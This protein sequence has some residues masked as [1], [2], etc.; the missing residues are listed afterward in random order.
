MEFYWLH[1]LLVWV[2]HIFVSH[3]E[4]KLKKKTNKKNSS[5]NTNLVTSPVHLVYCSVCPWFHYNEAV[6]LWGIVGS[7]DSS[8]FFLSSISLLIPFFLVHV[9]SGTVYP[10]SYF[11]WAKISKVVIW[12]K[13]TSGGDGYIWTIL[14]AFLRKETTFLDRKL[15]PWY[16][17]RLKIGTTL[18]G[19][20]LLPESRS[21]SLSFSSSKWEGR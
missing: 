5:L 14:L 12:L 21:K 3:K 11:F 6:H 20:N 15:L 17:K 19:K 4:K 18:K 16:L 7:N 2:V 8:C 1:C 10:K 9:I 13:F